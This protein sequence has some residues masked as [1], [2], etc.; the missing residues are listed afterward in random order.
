MPSILPT[1]TL[2]FPIICRGLIENRH[3]SVH[4]LSTEPLT[5]RGGLFEPRWLLTNR[6]SC[7]S[8]F[9]PISTAIKGNYDDGFRFNCVTEISF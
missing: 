7:F 5:Y 2:V 9:W 4:R 3:L 1:T 6:S 8:L